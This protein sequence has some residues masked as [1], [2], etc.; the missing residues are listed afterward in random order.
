M[1]S[2]LI[3]IPDLNGMTQ[4]QTKAYIEEALRAWASGG[5]PDHPFFGGWLDA[6]ADRLKV[7]ILSGPQA[8]KCYAALR[9]FK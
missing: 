8:L 5:Y 9:K 2:F 6:D 1:P 3:D 7:R 4:P